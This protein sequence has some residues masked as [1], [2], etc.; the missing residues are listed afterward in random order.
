MLQIDKVNDQPK[1][2][3]GKPCADIGM[4]EEDRNKPT[5]SVF[6]LCYS[7]FFSRLGSACFRILENS[8]NDGLNLFC[9]VVCRYFLRV[10]VNK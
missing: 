2:K 4:S 7:G 3:K 6:I 5:Y 10:S 8:F 1:K 9:D